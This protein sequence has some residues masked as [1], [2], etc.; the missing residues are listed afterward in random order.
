MDFMESLRK[1]YSKESMVVMNGA[2]NTILLHETKGKSVFQ[3]PRRY[4]VI[5]NSGTLTEDGYFVFNNI[6]ITD[7]G[8]PIFEH[9]FLQQAGSIDSQPGFIAFRLLRPL[10]SN[11]YI[12]LTQWK[13]AADYHRWE[14][15]HSFQKIHVTSKSE[16][17]VDKMPHIFSSAPYV[18]TYTTKKH[19]E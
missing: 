19:D 6:P 9:R 12:V 15:S 17:G 8:S 18:T 16:A 7:E 14:N 2:G 13:N 11:T 10:G 1:K 4:E 5:G 3:T